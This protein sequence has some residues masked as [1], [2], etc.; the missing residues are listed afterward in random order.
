[1]NQPHAIDGLL[2]SIELFGTSIPTYYPIISLSFCI[3]LIWLIRRG[4]YFKLDERLVIDS[5]LLVMATSF[6]GAR[7]FHILF[8]DLSFYL[9]HPLDIFK[10]WNGGFVFYGGLLLTLFC[11]FLF[12][13]WHQQKKSCW[14]DLYAPV[15]ALGYALGRIA[16]LVTGC[17]YGGVCE[18]HGYEF[19]HPTQL[20]A[21]VFELGIVFFLIHI[22][23][24][25]HLLKKFKNVP[26]YLFCLWI[27]LH[28][29]GRIVMES[30]RADPRGAMPLGL[31]LAT[32]ISIFLISFDL[33]YI[34]KEM[35]KFQQT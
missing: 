22:E 20:Y 33:I 26:G 4:R 2:P 13:K 15:A 32:W 25:G 21:V 16:C 31:S 19:R 24:S 6:L 30:F 17:C 9:Q 18:I 5:S 3:C 12:L 29:F 34:R 27:L 11:G 23:K 14:F 1:L 7:L 28:S 35:K 10:F 8:E